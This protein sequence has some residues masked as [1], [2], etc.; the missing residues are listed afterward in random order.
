MTMRPLATHPFSVLVVTM[1]TRRLK[2]CLLRLR[3]K[4]E[5]SKVQL[6]H[7]SAPAFVI[8]NCNMDQALVPQSFDERYAN[9]HQLYDN[10]ELE[11]CHDEAMKLLDDSGLT[12]YYRIKILVFVACLYD[13]W[14]EAEDCRHVNFLKSP[15][16]DRGLTANLDQ[17]AE[18]LWRAS[19]DYLP[20]GEDE[21]VEESLAELRLA[22]DKLAASQE[23]KR[24]VPN[25]D[26]EIY[27]DDEEE[28]PSD[29]EEEQ[30]NGE[31]DDDEEEVT[32]EDLEAWLREA[33]L[34]ADGGQL[35]MD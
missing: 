20:R 24:F 22:L 14:S 17:K 3:K 2:L 6:Y 13:D 4:R 31:E 19:R 26:Q 35:E 9:L 8:S 30:E 5:Y 11:K 28:V 25:Y 7:L 12:R 23:E 32:V 1:A 15:H 27:T 21:G 10:D 34:E 29:D 33:R 18:V 16:D